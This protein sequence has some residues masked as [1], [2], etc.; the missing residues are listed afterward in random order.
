MSTYGYSCFC[1]FH[2][3]GW[4]SNQSPLCISFLICAAHLLDCLCMIQYSNFPA[5]PGSDFF[6]CVFLFGVG[7][8]WGL[9]VFTCSCVLFSLLA[10]SLC[11]TCPS[12]FCISFL[13]EKLAFCLLSSFWNCMWIVC[14]NWAGH[15]TI[16]QT[17]DTAD[18]RLLLQRAK[19]V[20]SS[21]RSL[22]SS[23]NIPEEIQRKLKPTVLVIFFF[24]KLRFLEYPH[25]TNR[26]L[27]CSFWNIPVTFEANDGLLSSQ[28]P[29]LQ[30]V[31]SSL[32]ASFLSA[33]KEP[34]SFP[35]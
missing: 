4:L 27:L 11:F 22:L 15:R 26:C 16:W 14:L 34:F 1:I 33:C 31:G 7:F 9:L 23:I 19:K 17:M 25:V 24:S 13:K 6:P 10:L 21:R 28:A 20:L 5:I 3:C 29:S 35:S 30:F 18:R 32:L 8:L 12:G 2:T